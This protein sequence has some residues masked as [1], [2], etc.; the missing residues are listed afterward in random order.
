MTGDISM[1]IKFRLPNDESKNFESL[2]RELET[3][4]DKYGV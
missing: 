3:N 4:K 2:F 1:E